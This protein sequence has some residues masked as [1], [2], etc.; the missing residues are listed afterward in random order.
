M[1]C[2]VRTLCD[3]RNWF[4]ARRHFLYPLFRFWSVAWSIHYR[5]NNN[6]KKVLVIIAITWCVLL[7]FCTKPNNSGICSFTQE[8]LQA[9]RLITYKGWFQ[10]GFLCWKQEENCQRLQEQA[11]ER[12]CCLRRQLNCRVLSLQAGCSRRVVGSMH[13]RQDQILRTKRLQVGTVQQPRYGFT[14][15]ATKSCSSTTQQPGD[16]K[17]CPLPALQARQWQSDFDH[18]WP[19]SVSGRSVGFSPPMQSQKS[20]RLCGPCCWVGIG[21]RAPSWTSLI[22][23]GDL[24]FH[25]KRPE[26]NLHRRWEV[27]GCWR[28]TEWMTRL[29]PDAGVCLFQ[30]SHW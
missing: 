23:V 8:F 17:S 11:I 25:Y 2:Y 19:I 15:S 13:Q 20:A 30:F 27:M 24:T 21:C 6:K 4:S 7:R 10:T 28:P 14:S 9:S 5:K 1:S 29:L 16:S 22:W 18:I 3:N 12:C 26:E